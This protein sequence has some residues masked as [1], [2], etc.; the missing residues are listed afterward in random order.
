MMKRVAA[1]LGLFCLTSGLVFG[2]GAVELPE[3]EQKAKEQKI[4]A[5]TQEKV[6]QQANLQIVG[7]TAFPDKELRSQLKEQI[8][9]IQQNGLTAARADDAAFFLELFYRKHGYAKVNVSYTLLSGNSFRL[10]I[11]EGPLVHLGELIFVGNQ[12]VPSTKLFDYAA[13]PTRERVSKAQAL[14]PFV[15]SDLEEGANLVQRFYISEGYAECTV[16]PPTYEYVRPDLVT[17][18]I[19]V[20]EGQQYFFGNVNF[21]GPTIYGG[22][23]LRG[24]MLDLLRQP[25]TEGRLADIPRRLQSYY[26]TRGYYAVKVDAVADPNL[27]LHGKVPVRITVEPGPV[28]HFDGVTVKGTQQLRPSYVVNRFKKLR[29]RPYSPETL[30]KKFREM[31]RTGLFNILKVNP[32][33]VDG[34]QL[35]L[36]VTVEEAK[37]QEFGFSIGYGSYDGAIVGASYANRDLFG[38]G[39]PITT[40]V[41]VSQR[42]YKGDVVFQDPYLF[43]TGFGLQLRLSALTYDYDGYSKFELGGRATL[44][45]QIT[46]K[47][48]IGL[49]VGARHVEVTDATI[50]TALLGRTSYFISSVGFTQTLDLRKNPLV[51]PRGF[52]FD[53]TVDLA[54]SAI[55][56]DIDLLRATG[57]VSYYLSFA[58]DPAQLEGEDLQK[59]GFQK[60]FERSLLAFGAR[61]AI[62]YPL[63]TTGT[64]AELAIPIDERFFIGG[65]TTVRSFA[66]R[67]LGPHDQFGNPIGGEFYS[68]F[69]VEYT[70][71]IYGELMGAVFVD[72]GNL[73]PDARSPGLNDMR[74]GIGAG[75]RYNLPIGPVRLDY[76]VNPNPKAN[77]AFGAFHFSFGFAF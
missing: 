46:D 72:A 48:S 3:Q 15:P 26:K 43:N 49:V 70:F 20:H 53:N 5:K 50:P 10:T 65:S 67:D 13:G 44:S 25:F 8:T 32:T 12:Q 69:N 45:R 11:A 21:V 66:E 73:L 76:G 23:A 18:R 16:D 36:D 39:R 34:N 63:D 38:F 33:P 27:A 74:Y 42:G 40:S 52:V 6:A 54:S 31:M 75:L 59:S 9:F 24:Q 29:G 57:R 55:G 58:P 17:T 19:V 64:S 71:P 68:I 35:R 56:S 60:W 51:A 28:Y 61:A 7:N 30:D 1:S 2:Q 22:E 47:Y 14:L 4:A 62:V 41:E 77:E 37:P